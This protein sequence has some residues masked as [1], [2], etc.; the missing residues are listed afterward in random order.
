MKNIIEVKDLTKEYKGIKA[1]DDLSFEVHEGEILGLLRTKWKWKID[2]NQLY[3][4]IAKFH[5]GKYY[6][7]W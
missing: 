2:N 7:I 5:K 1:I 3:I 4:I 6:H